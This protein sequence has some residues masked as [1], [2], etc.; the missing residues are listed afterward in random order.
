VVSRHVLVA[1]LDGDGDVLL[2]GPAVR[3]VKAHP[4]VDRVTYLCSSQGARAAALLPDVDDVVVFDAPWVGPTPAPVDQ[5]EMLTLV[6]RVSSLGVDEAVILCS[7]HQSPLPLALLLRMAWVPKVSA[8]SG[9]YPGS[10][11]DV[12]HEVNDEVHEVERNLSLAARLGYRLP[13]GDDAGLRVKSVESANVVMLPDNPYVVVHPG[14]TVPAK[15][16]SPDLNAELVRALVGEGWDVVVT[17]VNTERALTAR[18][19]G[20][21]HPR[22]HDFGGATDLP[23]L[24]TV[25]RHAAAVVVGHA[26]PAHVAAAVGTPVVSIFPPTMPASAHRP[27]RVP[28][29][30]LGQQDIGCAG[31]RVAVCPVAGQPCIGGVRVEDV[32]GA[33]HSLARPQVEPSTQAVG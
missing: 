5:A 2:T 8:I 13:L 14:S 3:A 30:V 6:G 17:G 21:P 33:V 29:V 7:R 15:A 9:D 16:W 11:L 32:V 1:R 22:I 4:S 24:A 19:A 25:L 26:A 18:V 28:H 23:R 20:S 10:L 31:C 27:W 12:A